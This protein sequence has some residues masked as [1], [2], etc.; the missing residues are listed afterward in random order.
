[1]RIAL[2]NWSTSDHDIQRAIHSI[3]TSAHTEPVT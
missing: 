2:V 3:T 1:M